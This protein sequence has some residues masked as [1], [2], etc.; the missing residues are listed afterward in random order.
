MQSDFTG[1]HALG[2]DTAL[3]TARHEAIKNLMFEEFRR[4]DYQVVKEQSVKWKDNDAAVLDQQALRPGDIY[5]HNYDGAQDL[6]IDFSVTM[7]TRNTALA[8]EHDGYNR[9]KKEEEKDKK[10]LDLC[11]SRDV[12]FF[13]FVLETH[14]GISPECDAIIDHLA[15]RQAPKF[16]TTSD[17]IKNK[18]RKKLI[19]TVLKYTGR[20]LHVG[21]QRRDRIRGIYSDEDT[22]ALMAE[23]RTDPG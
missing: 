13:P 19:F 16:S 3:Q 4:A 15:K 21:Q 9:L 1:N 2:C 5:V 8:G 23:R 12:N 11:A 6:A 20:L 14:G 17:S 18:I 22:V 7:T 10:Y